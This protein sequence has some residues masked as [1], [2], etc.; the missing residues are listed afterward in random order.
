MAFLRYAMK[1]GMKA[2]KAVMIEWVGPRCLMRPRASKSMSASGIIDRVRMVGMFILVL[3]SFDEALPVRY[4]R[5][6]CPTA[7]ALW[8]LLFL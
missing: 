4:P 1:I 8:S 3:S 6:M 5:A 2:M 7:Y